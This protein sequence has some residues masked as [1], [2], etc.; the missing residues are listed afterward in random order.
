VSR[1]GDK[2]LNATKA[3]T[4]FASNFSTTVELPY[5]AELLK[6][7]HQMVAKDY[8]TILPGKCKIVRLPISA[9]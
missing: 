6:L 3:S 5:A 7:N 1:E 8:K 9:L 4:A 2:G